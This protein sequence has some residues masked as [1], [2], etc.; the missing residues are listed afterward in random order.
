MVQR[1]TGS[2][3]HAWIATAVIEPHKVSD[4]AAAMKLLTIPQDAMLTGRG[5]LNV[6]TAFDPGTSLTADLGYEDDPDEFSFDGAIDL[7]AVAITALTQASG[8]F[9]AQQFGN[10][11][12]VAATWALVGDAPT[13]GKAVIF[14]EYL[15]PDSASGVG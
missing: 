11:G 7:T 15:R 9:A 14:M 2:L 13:V 10:T 12:E 3:Q 5:W 6:I 8:A 1:V 4:W